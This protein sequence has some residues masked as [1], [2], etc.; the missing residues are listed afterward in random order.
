MA[1]T[2]LTHHYQSQHLRPLPH[3]RTYFPAL[4]QS[5]NPFVRS[6]ALSPRRIV[7]LLIFLMRTVQTSYYLLLSV[8]SLTSGHGVWLL[9]SICFVAFT[10]EL[11]NLHLIVEAEGDGLVFGKR[12][13]AGAFSLFLFWMAVWHVW[14]VPL[15]VSGIAFYVGAKETLI[16][17]GFW[18]AVVG[19]VAHV[20]NNARDAERVINL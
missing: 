4:V 9:V 8:M 14:I 12:I 20:A 18:I 5:C 1:I 10:L 15:E 17:E 19:C 11:W 3:Y 13:P 6:I 16:V 7:F 2:D